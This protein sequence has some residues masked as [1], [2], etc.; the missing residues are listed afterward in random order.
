MSGLLPGSTIRVTAED[1]T[2][3]AVRAWPGE[4]PGLFFA[5]ANGFSKELWRPTV[6]RLRHRG[7]NGPGAAMDQRG[8]GDSDSVQPPFD[9]WLLGSDTGAVLAALIA[10]GVF[11]E[12]V[13]GVGHS[14]G[15][16]ALAMAAI[17]DPGT[18]EHLVLI[19]PILFPPPFARH[20][21]EPLAQLT[22]KRR[23]TFPNRAAAVANFSG[24][25]PFAGWTD[26][27]IAAYVDG[28]MRHLDGRVELKCSPETEADVYRANWAHGAWNRLGDITIPVTLIVGEHSTT[29]HGSYLSRLAGRFAEVSVHVVPGA[30]HFVPMETPGIVA[31]AIVAAIGDI[32]G[33]RWGSG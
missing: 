21:D 5:H 12:R 17:N 23:A 33:G 3:L 24:R 9:L 22:L 4:G 1:G 11:G 2:G 15:G 7:V 29:H 31:D 10:M 14:S 19:E 8:Q 27:A 6:A 28:S 32:P 20:E 13:I 18:F 25:G 16:T 26:D 30:S